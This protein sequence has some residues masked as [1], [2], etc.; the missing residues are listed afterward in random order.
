MGNSD[1][2]RWLQRLNSFSK[3]L[4]QLEEACQLTEYTN[5]ERSGLVHTFIFTYELAWKT[6]KDML[7]YEGHDFTSPRTVIRQSFESGYIDELSC[8]V[9]LDAISRRNTLSHV[10]EE[11]VARESETLIKSKYYPM[12]CDIHLILKQKASE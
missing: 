10:Y 6:L 8:E 7:F 1:Q 3:A 2:I 5:L 9:F 11:Q 12:L 4:K